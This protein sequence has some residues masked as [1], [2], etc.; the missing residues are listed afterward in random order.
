MA[1]RLAT[2]IAG[3]LL[4]AGLLGAALLVA[5]VETAPAK[6]APART[7][8]GEPQ[9]VKTAPTRVVSM[10]VCTDQLA[11][12]IAKPGQLVSVSY[13]A[14]RPSVSV[15]HREGAAYPPNHG[16]AEEIFLMTPDLVLAGAYSARAATAMLRRLGFAVETFQPALSFEDIDANIARMGRLLGR[17]ARADALR[18]ELARALEALPAAGDDAPRA[19]ADFPNG[20]SV[21]HDALLHEV[22]R[23]GG[24]R[25]APTDLGLVGVGRLP[26]ELL[27]VAKLDA[28]V[29]QPRDYGPPS[30][31]EELLAHPAL[32][33]RAAALLRI[34]LSD[35]ATIC[36][37][38][39]TAEA[40]RRFAEARSALERRAE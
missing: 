37:A 28:L 4:G 33:K 31:A 40:A 13:L 2:S 6:T 30:R 18:A 12:L 22:M 35:A 39:F 8:P 34:R 9:P 1:S 26:L 3:V 5:P 17:E 38:P 10:N 25:N 29:S 24:W 27:V 7:A 21:G 19:A 14:A 16:R 15:M 20:Y 11:M 23:R 36:G 32:E